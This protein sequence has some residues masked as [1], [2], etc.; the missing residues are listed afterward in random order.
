MSVEDFTGKSGE[1]KEAEATAVVKTAIDGRK[2]IWLPNPDSPGLADA[3]AIDYRIERFEM[4]WVA[5]PL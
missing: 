1:Q 4:G 3:E 5:R 2:L